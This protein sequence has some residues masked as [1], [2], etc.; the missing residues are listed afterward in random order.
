MSLLVEMRV[1]GA[2]C[3]GGG[4]EEKG[5]G[6]SESC[7]VY[8]FF[9]LS[10]LTRLFASPNGTTGYGGGYKSVSPT[11]IN[12]LIYNFFLPAKEKTRIIQ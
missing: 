11:Y 8:F 9:S 5:Y 7:L 2:G 10:S 1:L 6:Y 12:C 3:G 4:R